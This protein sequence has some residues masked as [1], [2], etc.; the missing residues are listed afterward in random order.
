MQ[1][2]RRLAVCLL[3]GL[4]LSA[5]GSTLA[6]APVT[7]ASAGTYPDHP[8]RIVIGFAAGGVTDAVLRS[9]AG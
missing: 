3:C 6:Q 5:A 1:R 4:G 2:L 7:T 8:I 9:I